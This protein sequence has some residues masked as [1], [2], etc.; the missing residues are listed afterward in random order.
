M[1][2]FNKVYLIGNLTRDPELRQLGGTGGVVCN[3]SIATSR[4][5]KRQD[6][7]QQK[8]TAFI[9][10]ASFGRQAEVIAQYFK[11]GKPIFV[12]GRLR[13]EQWEKTPGDKRN[14]ISVVMET[15]Q[16]IDGRQEDEDSDFPH[17]VDVPQSRKA[18]VNAGG[19]DPDTYV[20]QSMDDVPF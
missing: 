12:E 17:D 13:Y 11:K 1:A 9:D 6:G 20:H 18:P 16:F 14:K 7:V 5:Y 19:I 3:F 8:E 4:T 15:F 10:V 2:S